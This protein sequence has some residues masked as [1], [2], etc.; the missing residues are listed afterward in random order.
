MNNTLQKSNV[1]SS[2]QDQTQ[3]DSVFENRKIVI[4]LIY[5]VVNSNEY[6]KSHKF[7]LQ[8]W[9]KYE[10]MIDRRYIHKLS[11]CEI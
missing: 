10:D 11:S 3:L 9:E 2:R 6:M 7:E 4:S 8:A 5:S 1:E